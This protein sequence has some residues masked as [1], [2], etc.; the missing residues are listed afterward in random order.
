[1]GKHRWQVALDLFDKIFLGSL[2]LVFFGV[3]LHAP[4]IVFVGSRWPEAALYIK[5]WKEIVMLVALVSAIFILWR[6]NKWQ[7]LNNWLIWS[8]LAYSALG[9]L[10][11]AI[12]F[13]GT[14]ATIAGLMI[15]YRYI[16]AFGLFYIAGKLYPQ[17]R[18]TLLKAGLAGLLI[19]VIFGV[20]QVF[21]LP[22]D[23]LKH[24][25]YDK[26]TSIAPYLTV[27]QNYDFIRINSTLRGPNVLGALM[28]I[29]ST[30]IICYILA[31]RKKLLKNKK[32]IGLALLFLLGT[33]ICLWASYSRSA[34]GGAVAAIILAI[35]LFMGKN[36]K[37]KHIVGFFAVLLIF[38]AGL[39][40]VKDTSFVSNV[41]LHEDPNEAGLV[42]SNDGHIE[43]LIDGTDLM[44]K[45][46]IGAGVGS[47]G[48]ASLITDR[49]L[50][51]ENQYL[52]IAHELGWL[53][54]ALFL[55]IFGAILYY[56]WKIWQE[57]RDWL[58][59]AILCSGIGL[60]LVGF[61]LPVWV[62][63][64]VSIIWWGLAGF[65]LGEYKIVKNI[66]G[67]KA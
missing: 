58:T 52:F 19:V 1:M 66:G 53:G 50:I 18:Q 17:F 51:I 48:S 31:F 3:F 56:L 59:L 15:D 27:D 25:G 46:P 11:S 37:T 29:G 23:I 20:L 54:M 10:M 34:L 44:L 63:D 12:L 43:S 24:I 8:I 40:A 57:K 14:D 42:N 2:I 32:E 39:F 30:A 41:L 5:A 35:T 45:Q 47:T 16:L 67:R 64:T 36:I 13:K 6:Q 55:T 28:V 4:I 33:F 22:H 26:N 62:D 65:L 7:I 49:P 38:A 21:V 60:A 61:L 9:I